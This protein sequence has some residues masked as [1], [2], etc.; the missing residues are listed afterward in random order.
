MSVHRIRQGYGALGM[1]GIGVSGRISI[2]DN[3]IEYDGARGRYRRMSRDGSIAVS[4]DLQGEH[5]IVAEPVHSLYIPGFNTKYILVELVDR[6]VVPPNYSVGFFIKTPVDLG[7]FMVGRDFY[8]LID[9]AP[10]LNYYKYTLYGPLTSLEE[11]SGILCR[12]WRSRSYNGRTN[13]E[14]GEC[15]VEAEVVN[16]LGDSIIVSKILVDASYMPLYYEINT[17][18]CYA[19]KIRMVVKSRGIGEIMYPRIQP[20]QG[21]LKADVP[22][23]L[24][25]PPIPIIAWKTEMIWGF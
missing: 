3:I 9:V 22:A 12:H 24:R 21:Y 8:K 7:V 17:F 25:P 4:L 5:S 13:I 18:N 23:E 14:P 1:Y 2:G 20:P 15:L 11:V 10:L 19:G 16:E 6:I